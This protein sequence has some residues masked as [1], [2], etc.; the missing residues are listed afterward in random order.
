M[1]RC[2]RVGAAVKLR[3]LCEAGLPGELSQECNGIARHTERM[4]GWM[5]AL[6]TQ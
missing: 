2:G 1:A 4:A 3:G 5:I 6:A